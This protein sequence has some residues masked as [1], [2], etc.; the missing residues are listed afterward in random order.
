MVPPTDCENSTSLLS[1]EICEGISIG[2]APLMGS[3]KYLKSY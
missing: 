1:M 2:F 3:I